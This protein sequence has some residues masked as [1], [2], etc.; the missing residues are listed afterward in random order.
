MTI[1]VADCDWGDADI[2]NISV[3]LN[4]VA[5]HLDE[6][7]R[8]PFPGHIEVV[9]A[10]QDDFTPRTRLRKPSGQGPIT[11]QLTAR[12]RLWAKFAYQ[13][14]HEFCH[15]LTDY[16]QL[17]NGS[18]TWFHEAI[19]ELASVF[20]LRHMGETWQTSPPYWNW[21]D[22]AP[23]LTGYADE[24]LMEDSRRLPSDITL[25]EWLSMHQ[26]DLRRITE[27]PQGKVIPDSVRDQYAIVAYQLLPIFEA[28]PEAWNAVPKLPN[29][30]R[31]LPGYLID[32]Y[33]NVDPR[34]LAY[35][36]YIMEQFSEDP[37]DCGTRWGLQIP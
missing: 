10:P 30:Q 22:Y 21:G 27:V 13:F 31:V 2:D 24:L 4:N 25:A 28:H 8:D 23:A 1:E 15:A 9:L 36:G 29:S 35:V 19:C 7:L 3:L 11:I 33:R 32:W 16:E 12:G 17:W 18:N 37:Q 5:K 6:N 14:S 20:T 26:E 34:D